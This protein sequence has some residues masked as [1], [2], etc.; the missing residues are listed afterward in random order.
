MRKTLALIIVMLFIV[1]C[2]L[3]GLPQGNPVAQSTSI[4]LPTE[5][6]NAPQ[7]TGGESPTEAPA[8]SDTSAP[9][10]AAKTTP[11]ALPAPLTL[12]DISVSIPDSWTSTTVEAGAV[13]GILFANQMPA[14]FQSQEKTAEAFPAGFASGGVVLSPAPE[15]S[16]SKALLAGMAENLSKYSNQDFQSMLAAADLVGLIDL[17]SVESVTLSHARADKLAGKQALVMDGA[18]QLPS[19]KEPL[20]AQV[21]LTW[22]GGNFVTFYRFVAGGVSADDNQALE[23][24]RASLK[25]PAG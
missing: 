14:D 22:T 8:V 21:W 23:N 20:Q 4:I 19:G 24:I 3:G 5:A 15:G 7:Q 17:S 12:G 10:E 9:A 25:I 1:A 13:S 11:K 2:S 18:V 6:V 16:D